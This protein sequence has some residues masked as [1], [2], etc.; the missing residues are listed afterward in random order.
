[1]S[2]MKKDTR[3]PACDTSAGILRTV[4]AT[5]H[6]PTSSC[7]ARTMAIVPAPSETKSSR[8]LLVHCCASPWEDKQIEP[9]ML[10][11]AGNR[12]TSKLAA[13]SEARVVL[14]LRLRRLLRRVVKRKMFER[15]CPGWIAHDG[16]D[17]I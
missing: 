6:A 15:V 7:C 5:T 1:M 12:E 8:A 16:V 3:L 4:R 13:E 11:M 9:T 2:T 17:P 14:G 10:D